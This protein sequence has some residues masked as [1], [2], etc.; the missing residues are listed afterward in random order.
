MK[1]SRIIILI[2]LSLVILSLMSCIRATTGEMEIIPVDT[3]SK[4]VS[5]YK[6]VLHREEIYLIRNYSKND[7]TDIFLDQFICNRI[8]QNKQTNHTSYHGKFY[9]E[10]LA[11]TLD[12]IKKRDNTIS[13]FGTNI[14]RYTW[15]DYNNNF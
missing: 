12:K 8:H 6:T 14:F 1:I 10:S 7:S 13:M 11:V 15:A 9:K 4:T 3:L 2:S 5:F